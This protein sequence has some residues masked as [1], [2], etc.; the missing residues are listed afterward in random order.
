MEQGDGATEGTRIPKG[1]KRRW[2][3]CAADAR[4]AQE[5]VRE[6]DAQLEQQLAQVAARLHRV[7][8]QRALLAT[9]LLAAPPALPPRQGGYR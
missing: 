1:A 2:H 9:K 8:A 7:E 4:C 6:K 3:A 5:H